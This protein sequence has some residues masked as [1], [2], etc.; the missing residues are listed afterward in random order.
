MTP[1]NGSGHA[2]RNLQVD[3]LRGLAILGVVAVHSVQVTN[4]LISG[5]LSERL[6]YTLSLGKYGVELF[7]C[8][9]GFL[10]FSI[11][12]LQTTSL[13]KSYLRRRA[14]RILPLWIAFLVI[15]MARSAFFGNGGFNES[16]KDFN[17][18]I[19]FSRRS[20]S[21]GLSHQFCGME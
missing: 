5:K 10:L 2:N 9:S 1:K 18:F 21:P 19:V 4:E 12:G 8:I 20:L 14:A 13:P 6:T 17:L 16:L 11:Y 7:F 3:I 15:G